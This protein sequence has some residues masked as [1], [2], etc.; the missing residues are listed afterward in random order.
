M[1]VDTVADYPLGTRS[2]LALGTDFGLPEVAVPKQPPGLPTSAAVTMVATSAARMLR[3][4]GSPCSQAGL[5]A[6]VRVRLLI[7]CISAG[8]APAVQSLVQALLAG[9]P[10]WL[11]AQYPAVCIPPEAVVLE[12]LADSPTP[13]A[14]SPPL[15]PPPAM[16]PKSTLPVRLA[17]WFERWRA[18]WAG[19]LS[20]GPSKWATRLQSRFGWN[21]TA[22]EA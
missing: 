20:S 5:V 18:A 10:P 21:S 9:P 6:G 22:P 11:A 14:P 3:E 2:L 7:A 17:A 8:A 15:L 13:P 4:A 19:K 1:V 12:A 16:P